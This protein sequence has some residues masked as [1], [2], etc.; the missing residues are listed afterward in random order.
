[1]YSKQ[2]CGE[3]IFRGNI[4]GKQVSITMKHS[5]MISLFLGMN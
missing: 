3:W 1:M 2:K 4:L 5:S